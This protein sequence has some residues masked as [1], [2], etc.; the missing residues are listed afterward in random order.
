VIDPWLAVEARP[1]NVMRDAVTTICSVAEA[2]TGAGFGAAGA[3]KGGSAN[4]L[5]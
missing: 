3:A 4:A 1:S 5:A 2:G